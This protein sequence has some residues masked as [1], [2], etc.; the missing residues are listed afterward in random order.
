MPFYCTDKPFTSLDEVPLGTL[1]HHP[2]DDYGDSSC[3]HPE[4]SVS[5]PEYTYVSLGI[6]W[7]G[8]ERSVACLRIDK[9]EDDDVDIGWRGRALHTSLSTDDYPDIACIIEWRPE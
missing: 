6:P 1:Y 7:E 9:I 2:S 3:C 4:G 8:L 5:L